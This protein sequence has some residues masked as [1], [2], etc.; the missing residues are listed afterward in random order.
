MSHE[1][2]YPPWELGTI[3]L[4]IVAELAAGVVSLGLGF[5]VAGISLGLGNGGSDGWAALG[6]FV[7][8]L[9]LAELIL[10]PIAVWLAGEWRDGKGGIGGTILGSLAGIV[11]GIGI[12]MLNDLAQSEG[13]ALILTFATTA[14]WM[15]GPIVGYHLSFEINIKAG[16]QA[17]LPERSR[18]IAAMVDERR[19][20]QGTFG[21]L[22]AVSPGASLALPLISMSF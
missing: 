4:Q 20:R 11:V 15:A 6:L 7:V 5:A 13:L 17:A 19:S 2:R 3:G 9:A 22:G 18:R 16:L 14:V 21:P 8:T 10:T 12:I 1:L